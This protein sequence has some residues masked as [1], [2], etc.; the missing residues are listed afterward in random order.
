LLRAVSRAPLRATGNI[1]TL[2][3]AIPA[4]PIASATQQEGTPA[5]WAHPLVKLDQEASPTPAKWTAASALCDAGAAVDDRFVSP[6]GS[7]R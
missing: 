1:R 4:A 3:R 6:D 2:C 7:E 5:N